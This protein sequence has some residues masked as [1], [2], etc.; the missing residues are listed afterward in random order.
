MT[1]NPNITTSKDS[2]FC[3]IFISKN[4]VP[5]DCRFEKGF[6]VVKDLDW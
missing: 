4:F 5:K 1:Q 2:R 3:E 6:K